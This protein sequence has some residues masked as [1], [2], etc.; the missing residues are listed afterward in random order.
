MSCCASVM[1]NLFQI[2]QILHQFL[3]IRKH[4]IN[5]MRSVCALLLPIFSQSICFEL[6]SKSSTHGILYFVFEGAKLCYMSQLV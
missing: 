2:L 1:Y 4:C 3:N 5:N 6:N